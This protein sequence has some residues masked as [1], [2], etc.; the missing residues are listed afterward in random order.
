MKHENPYLASRLDPKSTPWKCIHSDR[1]GVSGGTNALTFDL[2]PVT[3]YDAQDLYKLITK[4][5]VCESTM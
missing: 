4:L 1:V 5:P 2:I 3:V